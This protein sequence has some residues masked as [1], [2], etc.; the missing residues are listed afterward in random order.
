MVAQGFEIGT[1]ARDGINQA[2]RSSMRLLAI[3]AVCLMIPMVALAFCIKPLQLGCTSTG[4]SEHTG[5]LRTA[6]E[7]DDEEKRRIGVNS[8]KG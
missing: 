2:Y 5:P 4:M 8:N 1:P 6:Q 3:I 7:E